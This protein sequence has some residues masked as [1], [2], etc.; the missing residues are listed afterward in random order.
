M[1]KNVIKETETN[2]A[3]DPEFDIDLARAKIVPREKRH[4]ARPGETSLRN[5]KVRITIYIDADILAYFKKRAA[6]PFA[7]PY[8]TQINAALR[9]FMEWEETMKTARERGLP[10]SRG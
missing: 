1:K 4:L 10:G 9:Q 2:Q 6:R 8:Q 3:I 5:C 7:A